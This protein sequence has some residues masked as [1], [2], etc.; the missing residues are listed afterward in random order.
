MST[1]SNDQETNHG[2][3][4]LD[5]AGFR[6][7]APAANAALLS[8]GEGIRGSGLEV[9]LV[10]LANLRASQ[11]NGC[12]FCTK[13]HLHQLRGL[14]VPQAKLDLVAAWRDAEEVFSEREMATLAWT[15]V[16]TDLDREGAPDAA[17]EK[18]RTQF[19]PAEL[20][21]LT[22]TIAAINAWNRISIG[23]R[24]PPPTMPG[25]SPRVKP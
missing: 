23:F 5:W 4:R 6:Q 10:E 13:Y 2:H 16:L 7:L 18:V 20:A 14:G 8:L 11:M 24:F 22:A 17:Y 9:S 25:D 19:S 1:S 15:E 21:N 3:S 12:T